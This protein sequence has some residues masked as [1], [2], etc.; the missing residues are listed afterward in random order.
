MA[1]IVAS[2]P[3]LW[4]FGFAIFLLRARF[5]LSEWPFPGQPDPKDL[6]WNI[7]YMALLLGMPFILAGVVALLAGSVQTREWRRPALLGAITLLTLIA[8]ARADPGYVF[9]WLGD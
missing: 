7:H 5:A 8:V 3:A 4:A 6:G 9:T 2:L 1:W